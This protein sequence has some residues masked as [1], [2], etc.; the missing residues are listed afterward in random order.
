[1]GHHSFAGSGT[2]ARRSPGRPRSAVL[3]WTFLSV[4]AP[5]SRAPGIGGPTKS[6]PVRSLR[7]HKVCVEQSVQQGTN[8]GMGSF[9]CLGELACQPG[10]RGFWGITIEKQSQLRRAGAVELPVAAVPLIQ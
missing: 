2:S 3:S 9:G 6:R 7:R 10:R 4:N 1:M 8:V 5:K